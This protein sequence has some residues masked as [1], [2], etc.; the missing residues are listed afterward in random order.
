M[1]LKRVLGILVVITM[2]L[3]IFPFTT[4]FIAEEYEAQEIL[5]TVSAVP[6]IGPGYI[7]VN[8]PGVDGVTVR[9]NSHTP[10]VTGWVT[11]GT[12]DETFSFEPTREVSHVQ[13]ERN[14]MSFTFGPDEIVFYES[15][16]TMDVPT[17]TIAVSGINA[18]AFAPATVHIVQ[19]GWVLQA[20]VQGNNVANPFVVFDNG[21]PYEVRVS[22]AGYHNLIGRMTAATGNETIWFGSLFTQHLVPEGVTNIR[23]SNG[24]WVNTTVTPSSQ[25]GGDVITLFNNNTMAWL[26]FEYG[27]QTFT[28]IPFILGSDTTLFSDMTVINFEGMTD[29]RLRGIPNWQTVTTETFDNYAVFMGLTPGSMVRGYATTQGN[30]RSLDM[31]VGTGLNVV[32]LPVA[33]VEISGI[34]LPGLMV[35][36]HRANNDGTPGPLVQQIPAIQ[37]SEF[38]FYTFRAHEYDNQYFVI[39]L[40][41]VNWTQD[42]NLGRPTFLRQGYQIDLS[43]VFYTLTVPDGVTGVYLRSEHGQIIPHVN[44]LNAGDT[45]TLINSG[46][47]AELTYTRDGETF[48][49][50]IYMDGTCPWVTT[51]R[52][53]GTNPRHLV[54]LLENHHVILATRHN[55]GIFEQQ[56][57]FEIPEGRTLYIETVLNVQRHDVDLLVNGNLVVLPGGRINNQGNGSTITI[58]DTGNLVVN[59]LVENVSG[60]IFINEGNVVVGSNGRFT[61]RASSIFCWDCCGDV[62]L[63]PGADVSIHE[64]ANNRCAP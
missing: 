26:T 62:L 15:G 46:F 49:V 4:A 27:G 53:Y 6:T 3:G 36:V 31:P 11:V 8:F 52:F 13:V 17:R 45:F 1:K 44:G 63:H 24:N 10:G 34:E 43:D 48:V 30:L 32:T 14:G 9:Y 19:G 35:S 55:L 16:Y 12:G 5:E 61:I 40:G 20:P 29:V 18:P 21:R 59:G 56:S 47:P 2:I 23:I 22:V 60:S 7:T 51:V 38:S 37:D 41:G 64:D 25:A 28:R 42:F 50:P 57:V 33:N 39:R 58:A 54:E